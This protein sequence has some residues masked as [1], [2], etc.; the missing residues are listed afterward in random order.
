MIAVLLPGTK[1]INS[2]FCRP[3]FRRKIDNAVPFVPF[4]RYAK[5]GAAAQPSKGAGNEFAT[6]CGAGWA[7]F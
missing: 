2:T 7:Q 6:G 3:D 5:I 4:M 1:E